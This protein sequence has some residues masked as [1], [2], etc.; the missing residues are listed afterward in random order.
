MTMFFQFE[1][2]FIDSLQCIPMQVRLK[3]DTCGVKLKLAHWNKFNQQERQ[4]LVD[5]PCTTEAESQGYREFLQHLVTEKTGAP[6]KELPVDA[7]PPWLN[8]TIV[9]VNVQ[10]KAT[11]FEVNLTVEQWKNLT[12]LQRFALIKLTRAS[13]EN[14]NFY[15]ALQE[16]DLI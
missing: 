13:H 3:L 16:F 10:E 15:P 14:S 9:P 12:P 1:S 8:A 4:T 11:E 7:N 5:M 6:A 2:D